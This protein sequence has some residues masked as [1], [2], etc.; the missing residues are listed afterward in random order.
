MLM[1]SMYAAILKVKIAAYILIVNI[2]CQRKKLRNW[3]RGLGL[4]PTE[5][6]KMEAV[7]V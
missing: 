4:L 2:I 7:V 3:L 6:T 1:M 5:A